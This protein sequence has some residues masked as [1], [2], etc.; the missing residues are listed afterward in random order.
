MSKILSEG[1]NL[2]SGSKARKA[3]KQGLNVHVNRVSP[4]NALKKEKIKSPVLNSRFSGTPH[5]GT[6]QNQSDKMHR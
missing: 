5:S 3:T 6:Q 4:A 1:V 2:I